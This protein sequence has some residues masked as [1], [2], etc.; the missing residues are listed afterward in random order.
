MDWAAQQVLEEILEGRLIVLQVVLLQVAAEAALAMKAVPE[1][2][3]HIPAAYVPEVLVA[4]AGDRVV[5]DLL[6]GLVPVTAQ[7]A[8]EDTEAE[9][10]AA[11]IP[12]V[13]LA[14][15]EAVAEP[16]ELQ[17]Q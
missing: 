6:A 10:E 5:T 2:Q 13:E 3:A 12:L 7:V 16:V 9:A 11:A 15:P 1:E 4:L 8:A 17:V 14:A